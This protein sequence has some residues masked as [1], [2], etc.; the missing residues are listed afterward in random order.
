MPRSSMSSR[1]SRKLRL[2]RYLEPHAVGNDLAREA[3]IAVTRGCWGIH[4]AMASSPAQVDNATAPELHSGE[5]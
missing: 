5:A 1:M 2:N 3:V 4:A